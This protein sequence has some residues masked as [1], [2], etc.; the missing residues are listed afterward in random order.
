MKQLTVG[1][2]GTVLFFKPRVIP[3]SDRAE[4]QLLLSPGK[5]SYAQNKQWRRRDTRT[6]EK[7]RCGEGA[8]EGQGTERMNGDH[9]LSPD[10]VAMPS[11]VFGPSY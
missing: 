6:G 5:T 2:A 9:V 7:R 4:P 8:T 3:T 11:L 1:D 10:L